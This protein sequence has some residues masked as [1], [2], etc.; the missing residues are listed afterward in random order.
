MHANAQQRKKFICSLEH[1]GQTLVDEQRKVE[2]LYEFFNGIL[3]A[4]LQRQSSIN[5]EEEVQ[6]C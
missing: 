3:G 1:G 6:P 5:L 2:A 4:P